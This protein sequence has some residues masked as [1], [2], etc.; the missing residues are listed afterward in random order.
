MPY[1]KETNEQMPVGCVFR[2]QDYGSSLRTFSQETC[3]VAT[4]L[5]QLLLL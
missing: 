3:I 1:R 4:Q 2:G 5:Y